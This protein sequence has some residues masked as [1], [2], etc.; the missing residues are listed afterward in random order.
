MLIYNAFYKLI[1]N[2]EVYNVGIKSCEKDGIIKFTYKNKTRL[3]II[4]IITWLTQL[5]KI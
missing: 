2:G 1:C 3:F 5:L 4:L